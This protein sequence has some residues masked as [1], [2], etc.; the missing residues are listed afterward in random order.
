MRWKIDPARVELV[1]DARGHVQ[2]CR[3]K[4]TL[5]AEILQLL[6]EGPTSKKNLMVNLQTSARQ[7]GRALI[8]LEAAGRVKSFHKLSSR[9]RMDVYWCLP[10]QPSATESRKLGFHAAETLA[11]MQAHAY[12]IAAGGV[13]R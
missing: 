8:R 9:G 6:T 3:N 4:A 5:Q 11:A 1:D 13:A 12:L 2:A 7:I 10:G